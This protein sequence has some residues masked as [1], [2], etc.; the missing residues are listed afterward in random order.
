MVGRHLIKSWSS[1]QKSVTLS[2]GE[3]ELV[4]AV[5]MSTELI[6]LTQMLAD[7]GIERAGSV[8]MDSAAALGMVRRTGNGKMRHVRVGEMW[9]QEKEETGEL[10]YGKVVGENNMGDLCTKGL[11]EKKILQHMTALG[12]EHAEGRAQTGLQLTH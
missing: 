5:K 9:I 8:M 6:G 2:S 10:T 12:Q 7:W 3:A 4:A 11:N 1:T